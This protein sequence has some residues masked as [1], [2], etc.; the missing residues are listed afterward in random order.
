MDGDAAVGRDAHVAGCD[1]ADQ[2]A[3]LLQCFVD[4]AQLAHERENPF[5]L[6]RAD[7]ALV[8]AD[9]ER[10]AQ[11]L[12]HVVDDVRD[13]GLRIHQILRRLDEAAVVG[14]A[15]QN[16]ELF[17]IHRVSSFETARLIISILQKRAGRVKCLRA[18]K[19]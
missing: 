14:R 10:E 3:L 6:L 15:E 4:V 18:I 7:D 19:Q 17:Q 5:G 2:A 13:A 8:R 9:E 11:L 1:A 12:F 16:L